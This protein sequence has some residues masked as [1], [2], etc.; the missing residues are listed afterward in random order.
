MGVNLQ[1]VSTVDNLVGALGPL[2]YGG[3]IGPT[4]GTVY[5]VRPRTGADSNPGTNPGAAFK[6]LAHALAS[7]TAN[8]NDIIVMCAE[9]NTAAATTDYQNAPLVWNKDGV[10]LIGVN[11]GP[12]W[13]QRSRIAFQAGYAAATEMFTLSANGCVIQNIEMFMGVASV[14]PT[15]CMTVSGERNHIRGCHIAGF[16]N[17]ANDIAGAYSVNLAGGENYFEDCTIGVD[18]VQLGAAANS[19]L[20]TSAGCVR[21]YFRFCRVIMDTSHATNHVFLR[22]LAGTFDRFVWFDNTQFIN[23]IQSGATA[24]TEAFVVTSGGSPNGMIIL[25]GTDTGFIGAGKWN[26]TSAG[27]VYGIGGPVTNSSFGYGVALT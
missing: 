7:A 10:H 14:L 20:L 3:L 13:S 1:G 26:A 11:S 25:S 23:A 6:T 8:Q 17:A 4:Q 15:G 24:L 2:F 19:Q 22:A 9:G 21:N 5:F 12:L 18:T 27:N 16:G